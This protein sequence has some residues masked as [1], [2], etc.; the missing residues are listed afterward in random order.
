MS[1]GD[2]YI[3]E[4]GNK[5][6]EQIEKLAELM[7][8]I[9]SFNL[10]REKDEERLDFSLLEEDENKNIFNLAVIALG[11]EIIKRNLKIFGIARLVMILKYGGILQE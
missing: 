3:V 9:P 2:Y 8:T 7:D 11:P 1:V 5:L 4:G 10:F 6:E